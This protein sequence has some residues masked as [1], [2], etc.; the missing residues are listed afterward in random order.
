FKAAMRSFAMEL[1]KLGF[2]IVSL[3]YDAIFSLHAILCAI[4]RMCFTHKKLLEWTTAEDTE[5]NAPVDLWGIYK[6]MWVA[7]VVSIGTLSCL[8]FLR[9]EALPVAY[10]FLG[11]WFVSPIIAWCM[12]LPLTSCK[13]NPIP[14]LQ[15]LIHSFRS[16]RR[17]LNKQ[18]IK[19]RIMAKG[20]D[21]RIDI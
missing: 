14:L 6:S 11:L 15:L 5:N 9:P 20:F 4:W 19:G 7:P 13:N 1:G 18:D 16:Y 21:D 8:A 12:R 10:L 2:W 17:V 3:P